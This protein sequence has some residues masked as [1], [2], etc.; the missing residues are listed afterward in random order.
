MISQEAISFADL[1][2]NASECGLL[3]VVHAVL[4]LWPACSLIS[5]PAVQL[6]LLILPACDLKFICACLRPRYFICSYFWYAGET[7]LVF[8][9]DEY[10]HWGLRTNI[11]E[12]IDQFVLVDRSG[13]Y[14]LT[15]NLIENSLRHIFIL[16]DERSADGGGNGGE[17]VH[18]II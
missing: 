13:R 18:H 17:P 2:L 9:D 1:P 15:Q 11:P 3:F 7:I 5:A 16:A 14:F 4:H 8:G 12:R 6:W 10:M